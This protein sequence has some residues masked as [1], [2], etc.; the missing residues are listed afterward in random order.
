MA[1]DVLV[2][3]TVEPGVGSG[4]VVGDHT[5]VEREVISGLQGLRIV[6][7]MVG[8]EDSVASRKPRVCTV[9]R[10]GEDCDAN[11]SAADASGVIYPLC[12]LVEG[13]ALSV[14]AAAV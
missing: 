5:P 3:H 10:V 2:V 11:D 14:L 8:D 12:W 1:A 6:E 13:S 4:S 9:V 7:V